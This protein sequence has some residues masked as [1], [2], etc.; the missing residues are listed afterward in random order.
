MRNRRKSYKLYYTGIM[1]N[2]IDTPH[3][4]D[5]QANFSIRK[6]YLQKLMIK[7]ILLEAASFRK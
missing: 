5:H 6:K 7:L 1:L 3:Y 2:D 4:Q